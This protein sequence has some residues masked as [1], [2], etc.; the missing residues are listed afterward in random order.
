MSSTFRNNQFKSTDPNFIKDI[1][2][3]TYT[4]PEVSILLE[5]VLKLSTKK[6]N[7]HLYFQLMDQVNF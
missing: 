7:K 5:K 3:P 2:D 1:L 4:D 6:L